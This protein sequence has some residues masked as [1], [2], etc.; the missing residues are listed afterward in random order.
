MLYRL[1]N[2]TTPNNTIKS[3]FLCK[4]SCGTEKA[5]CSNDLRSGRT[6]S[7]GCYNAETIRNKSRTHGMRNTKAYSTWYG[8]KTRC[9]NSNCDRFKDY[10]GRGI[11]MCE[12]W[13]NDFVAF[14]NYVS[15]LPNSFRKGY[16]IDRIDNNKNYEPGNIKFSTAHEQ[17]TNTRRNKQNGVSG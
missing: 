3:V 2:H 17:N 1:P 15:Q 5:V 11:T 6:V 9:F 12:E 8:I 14:Y 16:S 7:C 4:C 10:G 13:K